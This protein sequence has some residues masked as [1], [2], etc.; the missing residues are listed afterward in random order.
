MGVFRRGEKL[1]IRSRDADGRWRN[2]PTGYDVGQE[3][4]AGTMHDEVLRRVAAAT[5][6]L[7]GGPGAKVDAAPLT[8]R[9]YVAMW[10]EERRK[11][12]H[13]WKHDRAR[14][15]HVLPVLGGLVLREIRARHVIEAIKH[16]RT[17]PSENTGEI[18][19]PRTVHRIYEVISRLFGDAQ[20]AD[21]IE[22]SPCVLDER[23][24]G[25]LVDADPEW[26]AGAL[27]TRDEATTLISTTAIPPDRQLLYGFMLLAGMRP[28][29][30]SALRFRHY[31]PTVQPLGRLVVAVAYDSRR[32]REKFTKT[33]AT[34]H[35]PVHPT[36]AAMLAE[37]KLGGWA[38]MM[39]RAPEPDDLIL[40]LPPAAAAARRTRTGEPFRTEAYNGKRWREE[41]L[42]ALVALGWRPRE[43]Y[44]MKATFITLILD[45][46]AD[47]HVIE[48]RVT[49]SK[50]SRTA[51]DGY[52][53]GRQWE[54]TCAEVAKLRLTRH[55]EEDA[56]STAVGE[57]APLVTSLVT[58][59]A[60]TGGDSGSGLRR[61]V[62]NPRPGG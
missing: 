27:F 21:L 29:E 62:S 30:A 36:L 22:Q 54:L 26:R 10:L 60:S 52:N 34:R 16:V 48:T 33:E 56:I 51:F 50:K 6:E 49:H 35:V 61:R 20:L 40:P 1:W 2:A 46:G 38:A 23:H 15:A 31:D 25:P 43:M 41:D 9:R 18:V 45:D 59:S 13:D 53:R 24:L 37:W 12:E 32:H 3:D 44:A 58:A 8:F 39:G 5:A 14:L 28:G 7:G 42:V 19:S 55:A 17:T 11:L 4:L 47:P 57:T